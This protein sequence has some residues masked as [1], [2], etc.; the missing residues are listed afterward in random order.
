VIACKWKTGKNGNTDVTTHKHNY[1][2]GNATDYHAR[3]NIIKESYSSLKLE[4][5]ERN[6]EVT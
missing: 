5:L 3:G 2:S 4:F 6:R 1:D